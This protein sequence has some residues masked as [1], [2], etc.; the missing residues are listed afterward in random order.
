METRT[1]NHESKPFFTKTCVKILENTVEQNNSAVTRCMETLCSLNG[2]VN[3]LKKVLNKSSN[4]E[5]S[6][7]IEVNNKEN[8]NSDKQNKSVLTNQSRIIN[9]IKKNLLFIT[10]L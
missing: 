1:T 7:T 6:H 10:F 8:S 9:F 3:A 4:T 5:S 2:G